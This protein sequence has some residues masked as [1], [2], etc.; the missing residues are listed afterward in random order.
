MTYVYCTLQPCGGFTY[1]LCNIYDPLS[2]LADFCTQ[3][4]GF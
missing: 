3:G 1:L 4:K 2:Q